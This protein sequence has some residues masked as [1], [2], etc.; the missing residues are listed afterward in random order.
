MR[1]TATIAP[2]GVTKLRF[3]EIREKQALFRLKWITN[4]QKNENRKSR[5]SGA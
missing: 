3:K 5:E 1:I 4:L 2:A